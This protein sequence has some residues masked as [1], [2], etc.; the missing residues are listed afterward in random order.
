MNLFPLFA[1]DSY[2]LLSSLIIVSGVQIFFF[3]FAALFKTDRL[4][5]FAYGMTFVLMAGL[6]LTRDHV[7]AGQVLLCLAV[8]VW[9]L[10]LAG[11]LFVRILKIGHDERFDGRRENFWRFA[12]FWFFQGAV[13]WVA[14]LPVTFALAAEPWQP[15]PLSYAGLFVFLIGLVVETVADWQKFAFRNNPANHGKWI[16]TGLWSCSRYP[17]YAGEIVLWWG[18]FLSALP[19]ISGIGWISIAGPICITWILMKVSGIPLLEE[20]HQRKYGA[21]PDW[22]AYTARTNLLIPWPPRKTPTSKG[23]TK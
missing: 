18:I 11:Y 4:T 13:I 15:S 9:G 6:F 21:N 5:D 1:F 19:G 2:N 14:L 22:R 12:A 20:S 23:D 3:A 17:N 8:V 16:E 10:R 7:S